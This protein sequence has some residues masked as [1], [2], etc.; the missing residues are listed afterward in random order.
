MPICTCMLFDAARCWTVR[1]VTSNA[2]RAN[3]GATRW[4][5]LLLL[6]ETARDHWFDQVQQHPRAFGDW[7]VSQ[8][9]GDPESLDAERNGLHLRIV[10]GRQ[11]V[12]SERLEVHALGTRARFADGLDMEQT[13]AA[14]R[15]TGAL[16]VLPWGAGKWLGS[17]GR[18]VTDLLGREAQDLLLADNGGR[19][20]FW[21]ETRFRLAGERP[22]SRF[23]PAAAG[24]EERRWANRVSVRSTDSAMPASRDLIGSCAGAA[25]RGKA[26]TRGRRGTVLRNQLA[27]RLSR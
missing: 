1:P 13:L 26:R 23:R 10:A 3:L 22:C 27:L 14:V 8:V 12:T 17:R 5:G 24:G 19:P 15:Q 25:V 4:H 18:Q 20:W 9:N 7:K 6:T 16:A 21:P 2:A 11:I